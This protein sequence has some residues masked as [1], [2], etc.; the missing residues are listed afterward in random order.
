MHAPANSDDVDLAG[1]AAIVTGAGR[2]IGRTIA[3]VL[4]RAGARVV[5]VARSANELEETVDLIEGAGGTA[6]ARVLDVTDAAAIGEA[7][8]EIER[9]FGTLDLLVNNAGTLGP[10]GPF[11]DAEPEQWW[12]VLE[13]NLRGP[14]LCARAVL[15]GM[16]RR[17]RGRI[18]NVASAG[19]TSAI[20][21]F[22]PYV[23][24]KTAL[25]RFTE[26]L[27]AEIAP[28]GAAAFAVNPGTVRTA[29]TDHSLNSAEG[30]RWLPWFHRIFDEGLDLP[31]ERAASLVL[32]LASG[33]ADALSGLFLQPTD[34][35]D[36]MLAR[37]GDIRRDRLY[38]LRIRRLEGTAPHPALADITAEAERARE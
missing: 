14:V 23:A 4:A 27:A 33:R 28:F 11:S 17:R 16:L 6:V 21:Y 13:V 18:V 26:C 35:L 3:Q 5:V 30:R 29:M 24:S 9:A 12:R 10:L 31:P 2:G 38:S 36:E 15:P 20:T 19:G 1:Q 34:D 25:I 22:S 37:V 32:S 8:A 7:F